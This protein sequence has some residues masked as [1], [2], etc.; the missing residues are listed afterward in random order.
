MNQINN[1][2]NYWTNLLIDNNIKLDNE[3]NCWS[4][5]IIDMYSYTIPDLYAKDCYKICFNLECREVTIDD[6]KECEIMLVNDNSGIS[7]RYKGTIGYSLSK[8]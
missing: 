1:V 7:V 6:S 5:N 3:G 8:K 4:V 2:V